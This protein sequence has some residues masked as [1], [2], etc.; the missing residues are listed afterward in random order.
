MACLGAAP[1]HPLGR[2]QAQDAA[3]HGRHGIRRFFHVPAQGDDRLVGGQRH[4]AD[5]RGAHLGIAVH[6]AEI[7]VQQAAAV[8][9]RK[10]PG[11]VLTKFAA[12][13]VDVV[14]V[15]LEA[16]QRCRERGFEARRGGEA[17]RLLLCAEAAEQHIVL[18]WHQQ[19]GGAGVCDVLGFV[20]RQW[21]GGAQRAHV[22]HPQEG[23]MRARHVAVVDDVLGGAKRDHRPGGDVQPQGVQARRPCVHQFHD[24]LVIGAQRQ[25]QHLVRGSQVDGG[26]HR[27]RAVSRLPN[28]VLAFARRDAKPRLPRRLLPTVTANAGENHVLLQDVVAP[29]GVAPGAEHMHTC[30]LDQ[31]KEHVSELAEVGAGGEAARRDEHE[32][33]L[34]SKQRGGHGHEKRVDVGLAMHDLSESKGARVRFGDFEIGRIGDDHIEWG[35]GGVAGEQLAVRWQPGGVGGYE[36]V[37]LNARR[38]R[39]SAF[40]RPSAEV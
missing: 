9:R 8:E 1:S 13:P 2:Q 22:V 12:G 16:N 39:Q 4:G 14:Q 38:N 30:R 3:V 11:F 19:R 24:V 32:L 25:A 34:L 26:G 17:A 23:R 27:N 6:D 29:E 7:G 10:P 33:A 35:A 5:L 15:V 37:C 18:V 36:V 21:P 28:V 40:T 31:A 20:F